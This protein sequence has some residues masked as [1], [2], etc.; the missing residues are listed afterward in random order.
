VV[1]EG[2]KCCRVIYIASKCGKRYKDI[3]F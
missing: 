2:R 3:Q 1:F